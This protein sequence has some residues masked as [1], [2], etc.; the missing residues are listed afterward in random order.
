[1]YLAGGLTECEGC[2]IGN[3]ETKYDGLTVQVGT[4]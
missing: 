2:Y 4:K 1:M 3:L